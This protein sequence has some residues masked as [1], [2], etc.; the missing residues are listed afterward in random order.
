MPR[1]NSERLGGFLLDAFEDLDVV[2]SGLTAEQL[3][4]LPID[5]SRFA[6]TYAHVANQLDGWINVRFRGAAPDP[7]ITSDYGMGGSGVPAHSW[8]E[9]EQAVQRVRDVATTYL[10]GPV[11]PDL[12]VRIPYDGS[13]I[14]LVYAPRPLER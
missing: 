13:H 1:S 7:V 14:R 9:I 11:Q 12:D 5:G 2:V 4:G 10:A 6:W 8:S 3:V